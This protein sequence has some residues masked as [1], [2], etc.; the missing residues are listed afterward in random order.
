MLVAARLIGQHRR[1]SSNR[2][3]SGKLRRAARSYRFAQGF[4]INDT[5]VKRIGL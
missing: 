1:I 2:S 3:R 4:F 5:G